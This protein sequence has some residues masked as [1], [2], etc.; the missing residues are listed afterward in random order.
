MAGQALSNRLRVGAGSGDAQVQRSHPTQ[1]QPCLERAQHGTAAPAHIADAL[2][3]VVVLHARQRAGE[4]VGMAIQILGRRMHHD[5]RAELDRPGEH[6]RCRGGVDGDECAD[7]A[8]DVARRG[9]VGDVPGRI[10]GRL[11][12]D[13]ARPPRPRLF[14]KLIGRR[15]FI[16]C[17][18]QS[19]G[20]HKLQQP[21]AQRP[22]HAARS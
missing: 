13:Q 3:E 12:P 2:P 19:P 20:C 11:D 7:V 21:F 6:R 17:D 9:N 16:P 4:R 8:R 10:R 15:I 22:V 14:G 18:R 5:S 1:Q